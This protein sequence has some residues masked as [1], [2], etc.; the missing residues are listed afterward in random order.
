MEIIE[1]TLAEVK[2]AFHDA[3]LKFNRAMPHDIL[4]KLYAGGEISMDEFAW[5]PA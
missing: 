3:A 2:N 4:K 5:K 1:T